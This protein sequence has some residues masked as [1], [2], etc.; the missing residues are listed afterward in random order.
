LTIFQNRDKF[1][2]EFEIFGILSRTF[3]G[4]DELF[5]LIF[6]SII[7]IFATFGAVQI[8]YLSERTERLKDNEL[9][10]FIAID[11]LPII[12]IIMI[13]RYVLESMLS[14]S[15]NEVEYSKPALIIIFVFFAYAS[16]PNVEIR[17]GEENSPSL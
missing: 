7:Y 9:S 15:F 10:K 11:A 17:P 2:I 14:S 16:I 1:D 6:S 12:G 3:D 8:L 5:I 4:S 13:F